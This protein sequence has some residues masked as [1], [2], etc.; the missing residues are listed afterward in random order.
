MRVVT[1]YKDFALEAQIET[2]FEELEIGWN[3]IND[4][5]IEQ[6]KV[7]AIQ[8]IIAMVD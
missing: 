1:P 3:L 2:M 5:D 6:E 4:E 7:H 8:Y